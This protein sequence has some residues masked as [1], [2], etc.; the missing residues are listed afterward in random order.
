MALLCGN[1]DRKRY[2]SNAG[3]KGTAMWMENGT[4][5]RE[6]GLKWHCNVAMQ[7]ENVTAAMQSRKALQ[8]GWKMV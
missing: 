2:C 8:S 1:A 4:T 7:T 5:M 3:L 6:C